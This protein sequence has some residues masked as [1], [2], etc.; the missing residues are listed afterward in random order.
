MV[1]ESADKAT[2]DLAIYAP[3]A[4]GDN[5]CCYCD[6]PDDHGLCPDPLAWITKP[7]QS[8]CTPDDPHFPADKVVAFYAEVKTR[9][10]TALPNFSVDIVGIVHSYSKFGSIHCVCVTHM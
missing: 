7:L 8:S 1:M 2:A 5:K 4:L 9:L 6:G 10:L 3:E